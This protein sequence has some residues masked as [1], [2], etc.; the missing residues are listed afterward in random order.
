[1]HYKSVIY[2]RPLVYTPQNAPKPQVLHVDKSLLIVD[3]PSGLLSVPGKAA[4]HKVCLESLIHADYPQARIVHRLDLATSGVMVMAMNPAAHRHLGLQ[5][6][7][8]HTAKTYIAR[9]WGEVPALAGYIDLPLRCDWPNR[10]R[11]IVD[12]EQGKHAVTNFKRLDFDG[13]AS[14]LHLTPLTGRSHQLRVHMLALGYPILGDQLYAPD[15]AYNAADRLQLHAESLE[16]HHPEGG[17]RVKF[18]AQCPF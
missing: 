12:H 2:D 17:K 8:R 5:F 13:T 9:V 10:P 16:I 7:R 14:R 4:G 11:Q 3:K 1:M 15:E 18:E 6:E